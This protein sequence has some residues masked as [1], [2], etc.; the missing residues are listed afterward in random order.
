MSQSRSTICLFH[1]ACRARRGIMQVFAGRTAECVLEEEAADG[2]AVAKRWMKNKAVSGRCCSV[3]GQAS[4]TM[5]MLSAIHPWSGVLSG[6]QSGWQTHAVRARR[7][8]QPA[9]EYTDFSVLRPAVSD[10]NGRR[11]TVRVLAEG[12]S[13]S[14]RTTVAPQRTEHGLRARS[15]PNHCHS[16]ESSTRLDNC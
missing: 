15:Y 9:A 3:S 4:R 2:E 14:S 13:S 1:F 16:Q 8:L 5:C 6:R 12:L 11:R 7:P 10:K